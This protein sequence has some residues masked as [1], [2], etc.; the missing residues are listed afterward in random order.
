VQFGDKGWAADAGKVVRGDDEAKA[1]G[2]QGLLDQAEGFC[3]VSDAMH[4]RES[5]FQNGLSYERLER[6]VVHQEN[7]QRIPQSP[8]GLSIGPAKL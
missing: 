1:A 6:I 7:F 8:R 3:R 5:F 2:K 4:V